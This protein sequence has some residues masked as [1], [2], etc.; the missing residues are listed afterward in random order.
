MSRPPLAYVAL[1]LFCVAV[2]AKAVLATGGQ[3][4]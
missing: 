2:A 3:L 4:T 1:L